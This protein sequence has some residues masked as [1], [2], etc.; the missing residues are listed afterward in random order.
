MKP[1]RV[2][3]LVVEDKEQDRIRINVKD[4]ILIRNEVKSWF[5][6]RIHINADLQP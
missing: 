4:W 3:R 6:I 5:W 1:W 2:C